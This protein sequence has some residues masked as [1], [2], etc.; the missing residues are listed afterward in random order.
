MLIP[1]Y[2]HLQYINY[3]SRK[4]RE[5]SASPFKT[6]EL[7]REGCMYAS[8]HKAQLPVLSGRRRVAASAIFTTSLTH[9]LR[10]ATGGPGGW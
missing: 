3:Y 9:Y 1:P 6:R 7:Y 4:Q 8:I 5:E 2:Y 10:C